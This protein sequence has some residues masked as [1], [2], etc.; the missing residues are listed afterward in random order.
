MK[1]K[2]SSW[3][4]KVSKFWEV[5]E[6]DNDN[7]CR[8]FWR[9]VG[10]LFVLCFVCFALVLCLYGYFTDPQIVSNTIMLLFVIS[11]FIIPI[12]AIWYLRKKV[13]KPIGAFK[14][15]N[16]FIEYVKAKKRKICPL[17]EYVD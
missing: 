15:D 11:S 9:I 13:G 3:H 5:F 2:R 12:L 16:I 17:I 10:K 6:R 14:E 4:Y 7:L 8:Y 1:I